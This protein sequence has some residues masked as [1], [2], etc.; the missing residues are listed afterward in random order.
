MKTLKIKGERNLN[1]KM[2]SLEPAGLKRLNKFLKMKFG[3]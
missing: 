2:R 3:F 1:K